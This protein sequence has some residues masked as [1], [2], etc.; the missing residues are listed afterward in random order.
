MPGVVS[1]TVT[2]FGRIYYVEAIRM[3]NTRGDAFVWRFGNDGS[4]LCLKLATL[5]QAEWPLLLLGGRVFRDF[6]SRQIADADLPQRGDS[7]VTR[8]PQRL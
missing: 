6:G 1:Q 5:P 2:R 7:G 8:Y 3:V 4:P